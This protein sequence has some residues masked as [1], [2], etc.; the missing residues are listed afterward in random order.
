MEKKRIALIAA[1]GIAMSL[2]AVFYTETARASTQEM[3]YLY[4]AIGY[5]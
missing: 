2:F 5:Q 4:F 1:F 3:R